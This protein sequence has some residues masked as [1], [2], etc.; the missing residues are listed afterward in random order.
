[1][2]YPERIMVA[3][4]DFL[5]PVG[6]EHLL[7]FLLPAKPAVLLRGLAQIMAKPE[8]FF[9]RI[10]FSL[11]GVF[12]PHPQLRNHLHSHNILSVSQSANSILS[13]MRE[14]CHFR[15]R[16][17]SCRQTIIINVNAIVACYQG[18]NFCV[19]IAFCHFC[20][21]FKTFLDALDVSKQKFCFNGCHIS[22]WINFSIN[23]C[24]II[25]IEA[26]NNFNDGCTFPYIP[27]KLIPKPFPL[28]AP[29]VQGQRYLW[30]PTL[31]WMV[32]GFTL[33]ESSSTRISGTATV[34]LF[35]SMVQKG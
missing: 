20:H 14:K 26:T 6:F 32:L 1:M 30:K 3:Q 35:G 24:D 18:R 13:M 29:L 27:Q 9:G 12:V 33:A 17:W 2:T 19:L 34:A 11:S 22:Q 28:L 16:K 21:F 5:H 7:L 10:F 8:L 31:A 25:I 23:M 4:T 15:Q